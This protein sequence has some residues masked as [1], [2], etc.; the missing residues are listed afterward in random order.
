MDR[1]NGF[2]IY[3]VGGALFRL[4][5]HCDLLE[6]KVPYAT[7]VQPWTLAA[8]QLENL[9]NS[10]VINGRTAV[11]L[12]LTINTAQSMLS[13][14]RGLIT[15]EVVQERAKDLLAPQE[16]MNL[17]TAVQHFTSV[18]FAELP[19]A[20]I[21]SIAQ[22]RAYKMSTFLAAAEKALPEKILPFLSERTRDDVRHAGRCIA[23][24]ESTAAGFHAVRAV[25][26]V[27]RIYCEE[28]KN[29]PALNGNGE[30]LRLKEL[31]DK[32]RSV[33][34][35]LG[36]PVDHPLKNIIDDLD[37]IRIIYRNPIM[38]PEMVLGENDALR[39]FNITTDVI[40]AM[41]LDVQNGGPH[42]A[43]AVDL[44]ALQETF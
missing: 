41:I 27:A 19:Q 40:A 30:P 4:V 35:K 31:T 44:E 28:V 6:G 24:D 22:K 7:M 39:V 29:A 21:Y 36:A 11:E 20:D 26:A 15:P 5:A 10:T 23:F 25:E 42:F 2:V 1:V 3:A 12:P 8:Q 38:H 13:H 43:K 18:L 9:V 37:R 34:Q 33:H 17:R 16:I 32:L 14:M